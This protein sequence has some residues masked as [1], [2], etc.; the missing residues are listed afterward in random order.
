MAVQ[1]LHSTVMNGVR[2]VRWQLSSG[3]TGTHIRFPGTTTLA[4]FVGV[5]SISGTPTTTIEVSPDGT[6]WFPAK[7]YNGDDISIDSLGSVEFST[8]ALYI[9][10]ATTGGDV[11]VS[12]NTRG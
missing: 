9:R 4:C 6:N 11:T 12:M 8:A 5:H 7:D 2:I 3:E 1:D 10:A